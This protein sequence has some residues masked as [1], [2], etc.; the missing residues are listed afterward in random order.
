MNMYNKIFLRSFSRSI[1]AFGLILFSIALLLPNHVQAAAGYLDPNFGNGGKVVTEFYTPSY[2]EIAAIAIQQNGKIVAAGT[3]WQGF[4]TYDI[5]I[6]RYN[7]D[8][9]LD[10]SFG[11]LG[12]VTT[13]LGFNEGAKGVAIQTDGKIVVAGAGPRPSTRYDFILARYN[14]DGSL[15]SSFGSGG[16]VTTDFF[17]GDD[18]ARAIAIQSDGKIVIAGEGSVFGTGLDFAVVRF[19][20]DGSLD[21]TFGTWGK[22]TSDFLG[23]DRAYDVAIQQ[24]GKI[25]VGGEGRGFGAMRLNTDGSLDPTFGAGGKVST[26]FFEAPQGCRALAIQPDGKVVLG[27]WGAFPNIFKGFMALVRFNTD[28]SLDSTF[29][30]SGK[31]TSELG[32]ISAMADSLVVQPDGK[33]IAGGTFINSQGLD[34]FLVVRYNNDGTLDASFGSG[35][36]AITRFTNVFDLGYSVALQPDG[37][38]VLGGIAGSNFALARYEGDQIYDLCLQDDSSG[39]LLQINST[40]GNYQ[41]TNCSGF[42]LTGTGALT[43]RGS[44][45]TLQHNSTDRRFIA[46]LDTASKRATASIQLLSQSRTFSIT[47]RNTANNTCAC[48]E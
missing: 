6:A 9:S 4:D 3:V 8:G 14:T 33:I 46:R 21:S 26:L 45:I 48:L 34:D 10:T 44:T 40:T 23:D 35:G 47:D 13:N 31:V 1:F 12:K 22:V 25:V 18:I 43:T 11:F 37:K 19:N 39:N 41:F 36:A 28:G 7:S 32:G 16:V 15:D 5:A 38:I 27:G 29:G 20:T 42:T 30:S 24:D 17:R 2:S